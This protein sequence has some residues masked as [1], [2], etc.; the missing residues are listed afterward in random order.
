LPNVEAEP[1]VAR[2]LLEALTKAGAP[3]DVRRASM[4]TQAEGQLELPESEEPENP[5]DVVKAF[6]RNPAFRA[7]EW[8]ELTTEENPFRRPVRPDDLAWLNYSKPMPVEKVLML[9]G[10]LGHRMLRNI[11]DAD[12][13]YLAPSANAAAAADRRDF[14]ADRNRTLGAHAKPVLERHLFSFLEG[15]REPL[16]ETSLDGLLRHV[17]EYQERRTAEPGEAFEA[18]LATKDRRESATFLLLQLSAFLPAT[19][20]A[21]ARNVIG[22]YQ[23][24]HPRLRGLLL[25][26]YAAWVSAAEPYRR[27]LADGGLQPTV[28][29]YWQLYLNSSLARGNHLH[30]LA[31]NHEH[32][33]EFL[34]ALVHKKIDE[35]AT[36]G[37]FAEVFADGF[38]SRGEFFDRPAT[39]AGPAL[40]D[41]LRTL[42]EPLRDIFGDE[43]LAGFHRGFADSVWLTDLWHRDL[44]AQV[45]WADRIE[46][47]QEKAEKIDQV[48][49][50]ENIV[51]DLDTFVETEEETST[52]HVHNEHRLVM[53]EVGQM[54]FWNNVTHK[55][56]LNQGDK[57]LIPTSR[58]HGST[59]LSGSCTYHQPIIPDEM[60][61]QFS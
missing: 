50:N 52:T 20:A 56:Q 18:A 51:V 58:L 5:H 10:L 25:E 53:I 34:G 26:E 33:F 60:L 7:A 48:I 49:T 59:V 21:V 45:T 37:R 43:V 19:N 14:Y 32:L 16:V 47:Y 3:H 36:L 4:T 55:I 8:E 35:D 11:Y 39:V 30:Y 29:A 12:L 42:V 41:Y 57:L 24:A 31:T 61:R 40:E 13:L 46:E 2:D 23:V 17:R 44:A 28:G 27:L 15:E 6:S 38:G 1:A 9:S 22:E 54:H